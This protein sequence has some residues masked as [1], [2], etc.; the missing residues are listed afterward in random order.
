LEVA[1]LLP[2][3]RPNAPE[4]PLVQHYRCGIALSIGL[5]LLVV[6]SI[7]A[8]DGHYV[9]CGVLLTVGAHFVNHALGL[10]TL[11]GTLANW[12]PQSAPAKAIEPAS[13][14]DEDAP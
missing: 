3:N 5:A 10:P 2:A 6:A 12:L 1:V 14:A 9:P 7:T 13:E 8:L 11:L 4:S